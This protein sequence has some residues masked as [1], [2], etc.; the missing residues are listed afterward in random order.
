MIY[1]IVSWYDMIWM[2]WYEMISHGMVSYH[3]IPH[4]YELSW[5]RVVLGTSCP[6]YELSWVRVVL[7]TS[8]PG[9]ELSWVRVVQIPTLCHHASWSGS[10][11]AAGDES[12]RPQVCVGGHPRPGP[13]P[14]SYPGTGSR[15]LLG[16][17]GTSQGPCVGERCCDCWGRRHQLGLL[18][19]WLRRL[20]RWC[21][22]RPMYRL[23]RLTAWPAQGSSNS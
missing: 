8:C 1:D 18:W 5:V 9:Y 2:I 13:P 14:R 11:W 17:D 21:T 23:S 16:T 10:D 6:G 12:H 7:G 15:G 19:R 20:R 4:G 3:I 22:S